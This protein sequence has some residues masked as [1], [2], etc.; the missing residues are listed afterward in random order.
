MSNSVYNEPH[1]I[2]VAIITLFRFAQKYAAALKAYGNVHKDDGAQNAT[3]TLLKKPSGVNSCQ[4]CRKSMTANRLADQIIA[5]SGN[6]VNVA[7]ITPLPC[8]AK[9]VN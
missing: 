4:N 3:L 2:W 9:V 7:L 8:T 5:A 1:I 6:C